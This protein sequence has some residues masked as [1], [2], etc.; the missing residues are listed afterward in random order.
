MLQKTTNSPDEVLQKVLLHPKG[1]L[2]WSK[3]SIHIYQERCQ[4]DI[5]YLDATGSI[6][7]RETGSPPFYVY[8]LVV[9]NPHK[10]SSPFPVATYLTSDHTTASV[11][12]F[13]EAFLTD[14]ARWFGRKGMRSPVMVICDGSIVLM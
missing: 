13:L 5:I 1:V 6:M 9:R 4:E 7:R 2:L 11:L 10:T 14:V 8:D 12:Y 3:R